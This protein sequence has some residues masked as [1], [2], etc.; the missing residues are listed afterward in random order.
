MAKRLEKILPYVI[1]H[2]QN[3]S[4]KERTIFDAVRIISDI[5]DYTEMKGYEGIM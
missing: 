4:V 3:A 2:E 5:M 1:H